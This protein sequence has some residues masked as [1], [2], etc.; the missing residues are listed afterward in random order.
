MNYIVAGLHAYFII[1]IL[2]NI[3]SQVLLDA[4]GRKLAPTDPTNGALIVS[5][6]YTIFLLQG[7]LPEFAR[8]F[9]VTVWILGI[10]RF[11]IFQHLLNYDENEYLSRWSW[12]LAMGINA[13]GV[14]LLIMHVTSTVL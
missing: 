4:R 11:G 8:T 10:L 5:L 1:G 2:Y 12:M 13:V 9:L 3:L 6:V 14:V 7:T